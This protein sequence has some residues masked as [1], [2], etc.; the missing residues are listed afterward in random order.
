MPALKKLTNYLDKNKIKYKIIEHKKVYTTYDAAQT[1]KINVGTI[2][3]SLLIKGDSKFALAVIPGNRKLDIQKL[4]K[5]MNK[6]IDQVKEKR[7][8]KLSI[9]NEAQIKR[10]FTKKIGALPPF[11][12]LYKVPTFVDKL[13]L[14]NKKISLNAGSFTESI[15]MTPAQYKKSEEI[16]EGSFSKTK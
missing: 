13:L 7:V 8:K 15:E 1:Q 5:A 4:K 9:A 3:K 6:Y 11:G 16:I 10:N 12:S 14:K 2:A